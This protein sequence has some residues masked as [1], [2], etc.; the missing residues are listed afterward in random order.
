MMVSN[1]DPLAFIL[2]T[3]PVPAYLRYFPL[4]HD[5][6]AGAAFIVQ[7]MHHRRCGPYPAAPGNVAAV[8]AV[9]RFVLGRSGDIPL[10][11]GLDDLIRFV[12]ALLNFF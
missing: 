9:G 2:H 4:A 6:G 11:Q 3:Y 10:K 8:V 12:S 5:V 1:L 7:D